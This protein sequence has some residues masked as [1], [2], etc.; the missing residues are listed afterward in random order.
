MKIT[1]IF[2]IIIIVF[3][4]ST[5]LSSCNNS[6]GAKQSCINLNLA[7][8]NAKILS[9]KELSDKISLVK[10]KSP[11]N[12]LIKNIY[13]YYEYDKKIF[14]GD[15]DQKAIFIFNKQG[16]FLKK[17]GK[18]GKG[19]AEIV[20]LSDFIINKEEKK[21]V[22]WDNGLKK[23]VIYD[24]NGDYIKEEKIELVSRNFIKLS[25]DKYALYS[26]LT[27][28]FD[29]NIVNKKGDIVNSFIPVE[30]YM[31]YLPVILNMEYFHQDDNG[32]ITLLPCL[33]NIV[34]KVNED[35]V[36]PKYQISFGENSMP[37]NYFKSKIHDSKN[38]KNRPEYIYKIFYRE[39]P[40]S[41]YAYKP[42]SFKE[43]NLFI[44]VEYIYKN[45]EHYAIVDKKNWNSKNIKSWSLD[46]KNLLILKTI[47]FFKLKE[48]V[49]LGFF[50]TYELLDNFNKLSQKEQ[51]YILEEFPELIPIIEDS[52]PEDNPIFI[53]IELNSI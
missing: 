4:T 27:S 31:F 44:Y 52:K 40:E 7:P 53:E 33:S 36:V 46:T 49:L 18:Y 20:E 38:K 28:D 19:P 3:T 2:R 9:I 6:N 51:K 5:I 12:A 1:L 11:S 30:K 42:H 15:Y 50:H 35:I 34:Y 10:L 16:D 45:R 14:L 13:K 47:N 21:I 8:D 41:N 37:D 17:V 32:S 26:G 39:L 22:I 29:I 43:S 25:N 23:R 48:N 24:F